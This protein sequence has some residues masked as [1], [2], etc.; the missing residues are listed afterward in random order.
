[1]FENILAQLAETDLNGKHRIGMVEQSHFMSDWAQSGTQKSG[2]DWIFVRPRELLNKL[3]RTIRNA[4][5]SSHRLG[6]H[7]SG[8]NQNSTRNPIAMKARRDAVGDVDHGLRCAFKIGGVQDDQ[9]GGFLGHVDDITH[10]PTVIFCP[11]T[12]CAA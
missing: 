1:M 9:I 12:V 7:A 5:L 8:F 4:Q 10:Q 11:K 3:K 2:L 6:C